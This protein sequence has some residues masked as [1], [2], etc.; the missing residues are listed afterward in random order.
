MNQLYSGVTW[1]L[2]LLAKVLSAQHIQ[3]DLI[4]GPGKDAGWHTS[5]SQEVT[6]KWSFTETTFLGTTLMSMECETAPDG[7]LM[8]V[9]VSE[10]LTLM[11][12]L[13][14]VVADR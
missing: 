13:N 9:S 8:I 10:T 12:Q 3:L 14:S 7:Q 1:N 11:Q 2:S 4:T 5:L 6:A